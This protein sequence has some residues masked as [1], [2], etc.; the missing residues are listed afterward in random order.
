VPEYLDW[1]GSPFNRSNMTGIARHTPASL[2]NYLR[3]LLIGESGFLTFNLPLFLAVVMGWRVLVH[4]VP[5]RPELAAMIAWSVIVVVVYAVLSDNLGGYCLSIRWFVPLLVP[6]FWVLARLLDEYPSLRVDFAV[7]AA[8]GL[9]V[10]WLAW[11]AGPWLV[12]DQPNVTLIARVAVGT[13]LGVRMVHLIRRSRG[14][15]A[16]GR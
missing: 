9:V 15:Q 16:N 3:E 4:R 5:D 13:W 2:I 6:G 12:V 8:W 10:S 7:L 14:R 1:P 11:P